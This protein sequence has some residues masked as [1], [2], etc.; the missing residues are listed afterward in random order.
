MK[1]MTKTERNP[2]LSRQSNGSNDQIRINTM[3]NNGNTTSNRQ[4]IQSFIMDAADEN[5]CVTT[6]ILYLCIE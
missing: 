5:L 3:Y 1:L 2:F 4:P 6:N